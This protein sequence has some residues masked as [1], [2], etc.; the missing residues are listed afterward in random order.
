MFIEH[1]HTHNKPQQTQKHQSTNFNFRVRVFIP[2]DYGNLYIC[3]VVVVGCHEIGCY[4][5]W[6]M[7]CEFYVA[8]FSFVSLMA[9]ADELNW[10]IGLI[11]RPKRKQ[12]R[13]PLTSRT[14]WDFNSGNIISTTTTTTSFQSCI[15]FYNTLNLQ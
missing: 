2:V 7:F 12:A 14:K 9:N 15:S 10:N 8:C 3:V 6:F 5:C 4:C 11:D 13:L 1:T